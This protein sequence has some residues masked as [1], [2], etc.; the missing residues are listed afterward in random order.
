MLGDGH[1]RCG[2]RIRETGRSKGLYRALIRPYFTRPL[3]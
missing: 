3:S 2:G 1:V